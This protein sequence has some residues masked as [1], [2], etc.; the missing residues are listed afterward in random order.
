MLK[1]IKTPVE[2]FNCI[3]G[4]TNTGRAINQTALVGFNEGNGARAR[5]EGVP[6]VLVVLTDGKSGDS[7]VGAS[8]YVCLNVFI[9]S[10]YR[11]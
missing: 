6:R 10:M 2:F 1:K 9:F 4:G 8:N 11:I 5:D 3:S 7:V